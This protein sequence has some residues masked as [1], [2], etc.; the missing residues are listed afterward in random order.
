ML[1]EVIKGDH[2]RGF[3][4][5]WCG[6]FVLIGKLKPCKMHGQRQGKNKLNPFGLVSLVNWKLHM[7]WFIG[8]SRGEALQFNRQFG[9]ELKETC[10]S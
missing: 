6:L 1:N 2:T 9:M 4:S 8:A 5:N 10:H 7:V 3:V